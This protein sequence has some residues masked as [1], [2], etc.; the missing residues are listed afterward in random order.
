MKFASIFFATSVSIFEVYL[1]DTNKR[2]RN[3]KFSSIFFATS[4]SIF[5]VYLK[6]TNIQAK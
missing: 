6:D 3:M 1:K 5:E 4:A 2:V